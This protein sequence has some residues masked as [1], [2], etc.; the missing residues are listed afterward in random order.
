MD[1]QQARELRAAEKY[2]LGELPGEQRERFEEHYFDCSECALDVQTCTAF[3]AASKEIFQEK[4]VK[5]P[6]ENDEKA[7]RKRSR[8]AGWLKPLIA[9]PALA[10]L[11]VMAGHE[12]RQVKQ[13][14]SAEA[15]GAAQAL[16]PNADFE[17][18]GGDREANESVAV[19]VQPG[20]AFGLHF[21][22]IPTQRSEK[23]V[24]EVQDQSGRV[25]MRIGI[26]AERV[27]KEVKFVVAPR[28]LGP[29]EYALLIYGEGSEQ[30]K[31]T[32]VAVA[33]FVFTIEIVH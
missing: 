28:R 32:K 25:V 27:N 7:E 5:W 3:V 23:Y 12:A 22:F 20:E 24:G 19:R 21:D 33:K 29:G 15:N 10:A 30:G 26:P 8:W 11:V 17:L 4:S 1:H 16:V 31:Q 18:R 2:V 14:A 13:R 9:I 6:V